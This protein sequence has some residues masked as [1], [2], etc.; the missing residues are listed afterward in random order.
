MLKGSRFGCACSIQGRRVRGLVAW[1]VFKDEGFEVWA[2]VFDSRSKASKFCRLDSF[3]RSSGSMFGCECPLQGRRVR[4]LVAWILCKDERFEI[5]ARVLDS[6]S[7][8]SRFGRVCTIR[9]RRV[10]GL[11]A[12]ILVKVEGFEI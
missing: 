7:K 12:R 1:I 2:R 6:K 11:V 4:C 9:G 3:L 8:G 10:R 5:S